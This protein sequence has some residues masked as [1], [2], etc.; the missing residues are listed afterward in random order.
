VF[1]G[2]SDSYWFVIIPTVVAV[3]GIA[4]GVYSRYRPP[5]SKYLI[6][7]TRSTTLVADVPGGYPKLRVSYDNLE[8]KRFTV[9]KL[10][11][12]N[13]GR[14]T[15]EAKDI[16]AGDPL[17]VRVSTGL[18]FLDS[19]I[20]KESSTGN[21]F[22]SKTES[23]NSILVSFDY[24]DFR[25]GAAL[26][27]LHTGLS[28]KEIEVTGSIMGGLSPKRLSETTLGRVYQQLVVLS[29]FLLLIAVVILAFILEPYLAPVAP[30]AGLALFVIAFVAWIPIGRWLQNKLRPV[31]EV[32]RVIESKP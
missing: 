14:G 6:Y 4:F 5:V 28:G 7:D 12:W 16:P 29:L 15:I 18:R 8:T 25:Q 17:R 19:Q 24:L 2:I 26:E 10:A 31:P 20:L 30:W 11:V 3:A 27:L 21:G 23:E 9:T 13:Q 1:L 22:R 32:L